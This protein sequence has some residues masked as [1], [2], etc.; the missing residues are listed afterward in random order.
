MAI[1]TIDALVSALGNNAQ[2]FIANKATIATQIAGGFSSLFRA[3]GTPA[4]GVIPTA[5]AI[6]DNNTTGGFLYTNPTGGN[7]SYI[8]RMFAVCGN[9]ATDVQYHD[10]ISANG[11]LSGIITTAQTVNVD[12]SGVAS[13]LVVRRGATDYSDVQWWL[14]WYTSTGATLVTATVIYTNAA[15]T[16]GRSTTVSIP[17]STAAGRMVPI[18]GLNGEYI[19]SIQTIQHVTTGTAGNYGVTA[20][21]ILTTISCGLANAGTVADWAYLGMPKVADSSCVVMIQ[22]AGTTSTGTVIGSAKLI[23]G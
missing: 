1:V 20:T 21:K 10:R 12:V 23:Q 13:N 16:T 2:Q 9:S 5:A 6:L 4:Q 8:A 14:E 11:G 15:G 19:Q 22:I 17:A 3:T 18:I 7:S